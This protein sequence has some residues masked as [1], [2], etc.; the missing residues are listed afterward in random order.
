LNNQYLRL[1]NFFVVNDSVT[2]DDLVAFAHVS[3]RTMCK[4]IQRLNDDLAGVAQIQEQRHRYYLQVTDY[5]RLTKIQMGHLKKELDFNSTDK[6]DAYIL[7]TLL[8]C[9]DYVTLDSLAEQLMISKTTLNR[10]LK[11]LR[12]QLVTY[13][14]EIKSMTNNGIK[15]VASRTYEV[16]AV[17][18]HFI[19]D[20][21]ELSKLLSKK[22]EEQ[23]KLTL[24]NNGV[25]NETSRLI[26]KNISVLKFA[27]PIGYRIEQPITNFSN[28]LIDDQPMDDIRSSVV[29]CFS[30]EISM[31]ELVFVLAPLAFKMT[32]LLSRKRMKEQID[33]NRMLFL[34]MDNHS[35]HQIPFDFEH[36]YEQ[37]KYHLFFLINRTILHVPTAQLLP[38]NQLTKYPL[39]YDL[40]HTILGFLETHLDFK[41][42]T[43][44]FGYLVLYVE[45]E[46]E[47]Q[48][49][50]VNHK[51]E[52]AIVGQVGSSV[53]K[54]IRRQLVEMFQD[55]ITVAVF[56]NEWQLNQD[57]G[58]YLLIFSDQPIVY[59]DETTPVVRISAAFRTNELR[60]KLQVSLVEKAISNATCQFDLWKFNHDTDYLTAVETMIDARISD[61]HVDSRFKS[62]WLEREQRGISVFEKGIAIPH[63]VNEKDTPEILLQ[64]GVYDQP[65]KY[66]DRTV[67]MIFLIGTP[68]NLDQEL[69]QVLTQIYDL[70]FLA[71]NN[72]NIY[73]RL[74]DYNVDANLLQIAE[75]I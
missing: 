61:G 18:D 19:Y 68:N 54:F 55:D 10:D 43:A 35:S 25:D 58:R 5:S 47:D 8:E 65:I 45:M 27:F 37:I 60:G 52:I 21:F 73:D 74:I 44:E 64:V 40:A 72:V 63:V 70:V 30:T 6:R 11:R 48:D 23:L 13:H 62:R 53:I 26:L 24:L 14:A 50:I 4:Y 1:L 7:K 15:L 66:L 49:N 67:Q 16:F 41:I 32:S 3:E 29:A 9:H 39:A 71:S 12:E 75:G 36:L 22:Q 46:L 17:I 20:Y 38:E 69:G 33:N 59:H 31:D 28:Y 57:N 34:S 51:F 2:M 42:T 56:D